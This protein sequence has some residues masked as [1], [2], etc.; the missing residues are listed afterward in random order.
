M[1]ELADLV[2][3]LIGGD[4]HEI[5]IHEFDHRAHAAIRRHARG[6]AGEGVLGDGR[7]KAAVGKTLG[8]APRRAIGAALEAVDVLAHD[9][10]ALV[11]LHAAGHDIGDGVD[12]TRLGD[13][14]A[15]EAG[16]FLI[17][18]AGHFGQIAAQA[19][20][21]KALLGPQRGDDALLALD[22]LDHAVGDFFHHLQAVRAQCLDGIGADDLA[23]AQ[24]AGH[25]VQRITLAPFGLFGLAAIA[26]G[27]AGQGAV[28]VEIAIAIGLDDGGAI[29]GA[30]DLV[31]LH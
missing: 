8:Q 1:A 28:L 13:G 31:G 21:A 15:G 22:G 25:G 16:R 6:K 30:H 27:R 20:I 18:G 17:A 3:D 5:G 9:D 24:V 11:L 19:V 2:E 23:F 14:G 7:A 26:E 10:D 4:P 12:E 29:A